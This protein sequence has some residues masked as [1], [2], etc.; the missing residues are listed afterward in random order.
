LQW[1]AEQQP[2]PEKQNI[3]NFLIHVCLDLNCGSV[4]LPYL[5][6]MD[7]EAA[8]AFLNSKNQCI[9]PLIQSA[10]INEIPYLYDL[11]YDSNFLAAD[12]KV[13]LAARMKIIADAWIGFLTALQ[14]DF[15]FYHK[16][17][18]CGL[19]GS[20]FYGDKETLSENLQA[21][22]QDI[23]QNPANC[24]KLINILNTYFSNFV[25]TLIAGHSKRYLGNFCRFL[26]YDGKPATAKSMDFFTLVS[27][28]VM[29]YVNEQ[30]PAPR[31]A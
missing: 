19:F 29:S 11:L 27:A 16:K 26:G 20:K 31:L 4:A 17:N 3:H 5:Q 15:T 8:R 21:I 12:V 14:T 22:Q 24:Y 10:P 23:Q 28:K 2:Y 30:S 13:M 18:A 25:G 9:G 1:Y 6:L 7:S